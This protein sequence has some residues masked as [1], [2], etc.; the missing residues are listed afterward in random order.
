M[1]KKTGRSNN[2]QLAGL[3]VLVVV[4][5]I[6]LSSIFKVIFLIKDSKF[7]GA[8]KFNVE[9]S[10]KEKTSIVSFSP[11]AKSISIL[12]TNKK[13]NENLGKLY[14]AIIDGKIITKEEVK[15][16][17]LSS[18]LLKSTLPFGNKVESLTIIDL[19]RLT[20]FSRS[21]SKNSIYERE[22]LDKYNEAQ[23]STTISL[24]L[25]DPHIYQ[26]NQSIEVVNATNVFG[27]GGRLALLISN[28]GGNVIL[29]SS[30]KK[31]MNTSKIMYFGEKT[32]TVRRIGEYLDFPIE[33][34]DKKGIADVIIIIGTDKLENS[35]F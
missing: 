22:I 1:S 7:D 14:G 27:L 24:S 25:T 15:N 28:L 29:V 3:F 33:K 10:G 5:L 32:Y 34:T 20:L 31:E 35:K 2:M 9:F 19:V 18:I 8:H 30:E 17:N 4:G 26:E 11:Q 21:V 6:I 23:K 13:S 12:R 16:D